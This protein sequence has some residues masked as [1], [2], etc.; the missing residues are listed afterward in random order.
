MQW[1]H[2]DEQAPE[3]EYQAATF[4]CSI[5]LAPTVNIVYLNER[6]VR[7]VLVTGGSGTAK[8]SN[9][10]QCAASEHCGEMAL[11]KGEL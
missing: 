6:I 11:K 7:P 3:F 1:V 4:K 2:W 10:L 5:S 9:V 8:T